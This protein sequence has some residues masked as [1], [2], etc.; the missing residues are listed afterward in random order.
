MSIFT[1]FFRRTGEAP[2]L[3]KPFQCEHCD[4][5]FTH[6]SNYTSHID[7]Y[8][9]FKRPCNV[10][11]CKEEL[12][13]IT[14]FVQHYV[15]H[16]DATVTVP[17]DFKGK[18]SIELECPLCTVKAYGIWKYYQHTFVHDSVAR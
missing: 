9:G 7:H 5:C 16:V 2:S 1:Y 12:T 17:S 3:N 8:H 13:S 4:K 15:R 10:E 18:Q 14:D 11:N 6:Y